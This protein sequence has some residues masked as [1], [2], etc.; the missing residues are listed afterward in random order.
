MSVLYCRIPYFAASLVRRDDPDLQ[1]QPLALI[2]PEGQVFG[3]SAEAASCGIV[4]SMTA[5]QAEIRCP[6]ARL[7]DADLAHCR[8]E[9]EIL[10]QLLETISPKVEPHGL[11][12][13]YADVSDL[14]QDHQ[15]AV[16][17][18]RQVG[19]AVRR[20]L[21]QTLQPA[22]GWDNGKFT[23]QTA[24]R[25]TQPGY[26]LVVDR[27][28]EKTFLQPLPVTL[29][30]LATENLQRLGFL[31]LRTLGQYAALPPSAVLQQFGKAGQLAQRYAQAKDDRPVISRWQTPR[32]M[33]SCELDAPL[34]DRERL[35]ATVEQL[36]SPALAELQAQLQAC[37]Q[38]RLTVD[39]DDGSTQER[40]RTLLF[41]TAN[42]AHVMR[43]LDQ[44]ASKM[45]WPAPAIAL[46]VK[47]GQIQ[48]TVV[49]QLSLFPVKN[50]RE[51]K[52][53]EVQRYLVTRFGAARLRRAILS[54]PGAPLPEWRV[55][56]LEGDDE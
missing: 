52:L 12:A 56:W 25:R 40:T 27:P 13:V 16:G 3:V 8:E 5:R 14:A 44:L 10:M 19:Q 11:G 6:E 22:L 49:E 4:V 37:G 47:L 36:V 9:F 54:Q 33:V 32:R 29:L 41:P 28:R 2:G 51:Q 43:I 21:G 31:G 38:V 18:C 7:L 35:I 48:D 26:L 17:I 15:G 42:Q 24:T 39:F 53:R 34:D 45:H 30:P 20:E 23:A 1:E 46:S 50:K 55:G